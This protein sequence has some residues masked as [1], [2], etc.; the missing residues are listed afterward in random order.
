MDQ[1]DK[2]PLDRMYLYKMGSLIMPLQNGHFPTHD[3]KPQKGCADPGWPSVMKLF[4][5][6]ENTQ[7]SGQISPRPH[8]PTWAP[9]FGIILEGK[10]P[11]ISGKS[12]WM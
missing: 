8:E 11:A 6:T 4:Q 5:A 10:S 7:A 3:N 2:H 9:N 12:R 1:D